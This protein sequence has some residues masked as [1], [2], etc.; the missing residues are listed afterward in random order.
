FIEG[1]QG[2]GKSTLLAE[3]ARRRPEYKVCREG[4]YS[5][6][7]LAWCAWMDGE[8]YAAVLEQYSPIR[9]EIEVGTFREGEHYIV[10][11]TKIITDI[12]GFHRDLEQYEIYNGRRSLEELERIVFG[13]YERFHGSGY[14]FECAFL[15]NIVED[16]ILFHQLSDE[17]ILDFYRRLYA[18]MPREHFRLLYL[19]SDKIAENIRIIQKERSD[20]QGNQLWYSLMMEYLVNSPYGKVHEYKDFEDLISHLKHRQQVELRIIREI[21]GD[22]AAIL[23][24]K[25]N[26]NLKTMIY[27]LA[28]G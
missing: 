21:I 20:D 17:E 19:Y 7:E 24:A 26:F 11:Y 8:Q 16:L 5:P 27:S 10:T 23:P 22:R 25:E 6:V 3:I 14:L 13:R 2:M 1:L 4:D 9:K 12:P 18:V 15:Q 28:S